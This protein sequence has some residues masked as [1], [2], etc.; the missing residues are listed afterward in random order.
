MDDDIDKEDYMEIATPIKPS[1]EEYE[2]QINMMLD[3]LNLLLN[4]KRK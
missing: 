2:R 4:K 1:S 3:D